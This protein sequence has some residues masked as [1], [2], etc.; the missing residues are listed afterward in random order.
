MPDTSLSLRSTTVNL[1]KFSVACLQRSMIWSRRFFV[2][3]KVRT[4]RHLIQQHRGLDL[5]QSM[6]ETV[7]QFSWLSLY[8]ISA[9]QVQHSSNSKFSMYH[10]FLLTLSGSQLDWNQLSISPCHDWGYIAPLQCVCPR[11]GQFHHASQKQPICHQVNWQVSGRNP[12][13]ITEIQNTWK[14]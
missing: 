3:V 14:S 4:L 12:V 7:K 2:M 5:T 11:C 8:S 9:L 13:K 10:P 1:F 6:A